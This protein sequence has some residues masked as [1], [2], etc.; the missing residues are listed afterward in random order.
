MAGLH[1]ELVSP[2]RLLFSGDVTSVIIPGTEGE[3]TILPQHAPVLSTLRPGIVTVAKDGGTSE[4]IFVRG[5]FAEVNA[6]GLTVL[7]ETAIP[8]AEL[9]A[10]AMS[11][12]IKTAEEEVAAAKDDEGKRKALENV[13]HLKGLQAAM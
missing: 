12:Q 1:F 13:E 10:S 8:M 9:D 5:G 7:A 2:A 3:M 11:A 6:K 4:K